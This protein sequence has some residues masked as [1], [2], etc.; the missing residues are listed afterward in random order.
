MSPIDVTD[1][2]Y[3]ASK[4]HAPDKSSTWPYPVEMDGE[5][6]EDLFGVVMRTLTTRTS[7]CLSIL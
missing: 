4:D 6:N 3:Q 7:V 2:K 5:K 1:K